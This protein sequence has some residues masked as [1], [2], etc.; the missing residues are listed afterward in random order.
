MTSRLA[1]RLLRGSIVLVLAV[2]GTFLTTEAAAQERPGFRG[3]MERAER[4]RDRGET[5]GRFGQPDERRRGFR[6]RGGGDDGPDARRGWGGPGGPGGMFGG[7]MRPG[8]ERRDLQVLDRELDLD[9]AQQSIAE[10]LMADY[11]DG[12]RAAAGELREEMRASRPEM[13]VDEETRARFSEMRDEARELRRRMRDAEEDGLTDE[14]RER[15]SAELRARIERIREEA[16]A[17]RPSEEERNEATLAMASIL[18]EWNRTRRALDE[19]FRDELGLILTD[20]QL[21]RLPEVER[22]VRRARLLPL[23]RLSAESIDLTQLPRQAG[24]EEVVAPVLEPLWSEYEQLLDDALVARDAHLDGMG[25][26][27]MDAFRTRDPTLAIEATRTEARLRE[28]V[29]DVNLRMHEM[30]VALLGEA[31]VEST[32]VTE[33]DM[34]FRREAFARA[35]GPTFASRSFRAAAGLEDLSPETAALVA[36]LEAAYTAEVAG[37]NSA[38][39]VEIVATDGDRLISR[40]ERLA[41]RMQGM[42]NDLPV[43][44][45]PVRDLL[46]R[47]QDLD[48]RFREQLESLLTPEQIAALPESPEQRRERILAEREERMRRFVQEFDRDGDGELS[49]E[50]WRAAREAMRERFRGNRGGDRDDD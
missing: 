21:E 33:Y 22:D 13:N 41:A 37:L 3:A 24:V 43:A 48:R 40:M 35:W 28:A 19:A 9:E 46:E 31:G 42:D 39:E 12:F 11:L 23:G 47:R 38:I 1:G 6:G 4:G 30:A 10:A 20:E 14:D 32:A 49:G 45:Q 15:M 8:W 36:Q 16:R 17:M 34:A 29:R 25:I 50:E 2:P 44:D 27:M 18:S 5:M 26:T 7:M